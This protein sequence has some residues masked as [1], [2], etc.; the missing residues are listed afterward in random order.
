M[1]VRLVI[2]VV[3]AHF[4]VVVA[5]FFVVVAH[6]VVVVVACFARLKNYTKLKF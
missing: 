4:F 2:G 1:A 3:V 5:H 6:F